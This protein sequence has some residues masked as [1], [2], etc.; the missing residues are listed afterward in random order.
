M[1]HASGPIC[2]SQGQYS[3]T[4]GQVRRSSLSMSY[5]LTLVTIGPKQ[6]D[7][8]DQQRYINLNAFCAR[9]FGSGVVTWKPNFAI[10]ALRDALE[11]DQAE[12]SSCYLAA[13]LLW[14]EHA[15]QCL[16]DWLRRGDGDEQFV[17]ITAP[18]DL[19]KGPGGL[20]VERWNFWKSRLESLASKSGSDGLEERARAA[21]EI[22]TSVESRQ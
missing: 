11:S 2:R 5:K 13:A 3:G 21:A 9:L 4:L 10:W 7:K 20:P 12:P 19:Y 17:G 18:G 1:N 14:I 22:M 15:G 8:L 16:Y 6:G